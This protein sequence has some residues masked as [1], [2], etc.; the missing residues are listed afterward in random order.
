[1]PN[2][3]FILYFLLHSH[4]GRVPCHNSGME[5]TECLDPIYPKGHLIN[6]DTIHS[7]T[8]GAHGETTI[9]QLIGWISNDYIKLHLPSKY[10][11]KPSLD[12][13]GINKTIG[14]VLGDRPLPFL[15]GDGIFAKIIVE[16]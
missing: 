10:L 11:G 13:V 5:P 7:D 15:L 2:G 9:I 16:T 12:V 6:S 4:P 8:N 1:M 3:D 14:M